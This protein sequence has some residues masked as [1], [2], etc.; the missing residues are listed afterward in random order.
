MLRASLWRA[1]LVIWGI[2]MLWPLTAWGEGKFTLSGFVDASFFYE[3]L[4]HTNTFSLDEVELDIQAELQSWAGLR[5]DINFRAADSGTVNTDVVGTQ[6]ISF[7]DLSADDIMEQGYMYL[8]LPTQKL[9]LPFEATFRFGKFNA[10]IG[11]ELL[12]PVDAYQFSRS[13][14]F[15]F[16]TP[17]NITGALLAFIFTPVVDL[18]LYAVNGWDRL[19]D[20]NKRKTFG[21]RLGLTPIKDVN[22]GL[23]LITGPEQDDNDD[24]Y[25]TVFDT[26]LTIQLIPSLV[27]GVEFNYGWEKN[28]ALG[29]GDA[30]WMGGLL[31]GHYNFT[32]IIGLTFRFDIF[33]DKDGA[34]LPNDN[35]AVRQQTAYALTLAPIFALADNMRLLFEFRYDKSNRDVFQK[36]NG[37]FRD[38]IFSVAVEFTYSF[39]HMFDIVVR[40]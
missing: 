20:N 16:G 8:V 25:R 21:G 34:R 22:W 1:G 10:P 26:D 18:Q 35:P 32:D 38:D 33:D 39:K 29:G 12:D 14:V 17:S 31:T 4:R 36:D 13:R 27:I 11:W 24:D 9:G 23:S 19:R 7:D 37:R 6:V 40:Q 15:N 30:K 2:F 28:A 3:N 5:T